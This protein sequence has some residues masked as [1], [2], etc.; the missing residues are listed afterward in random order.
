MPMAHRAEVDFNS[1]DEFG[2]IPVDPSDLSEPVEVGDWV[3]LFDD[4]GNRC[5]GLVAVIGE[6]ISVS[7]MWPSFTTATASR[8]VV[9][10]STFWPRIQW[11]GGLSVTLGTE[12]GPFERLS[13]EAPTSQSV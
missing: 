1:R 9:E 4:A 5:M 8:I 11:L 3:D 13:R 7:P 2:N 10:S 12:D 6:D